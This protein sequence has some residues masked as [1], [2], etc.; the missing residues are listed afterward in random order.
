[1]TDTIR[2]D[3]LQLKKLIREAEAVTD[4]ATLI[5]AR[6]KQAMV[7]SRQNPEVPVATGQRAMVRLSRAEQQILEAST[8]LFRV[9]EELSRIAP[10]FGLGDEKTEVEPMGVTAEPVSEA[11]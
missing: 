7:A 2:N 4:E 6:L 1:M 9:H 3:A 10:V 11:A 8:N 5:Y